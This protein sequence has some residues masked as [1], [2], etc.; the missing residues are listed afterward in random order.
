VYGDV[1]RLSAQSLDR[2]QLLTGTLDPWDLIYTTRLKNFQNEGRFQTTL[3]FDREY[4]RSGLE[5]QKSEMQVID[6]NRS[7]FGDKNWVNFGPLI[8]KL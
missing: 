1:W 2:A 4:L 8:K 5:Y 6:Y 3:D 7:T